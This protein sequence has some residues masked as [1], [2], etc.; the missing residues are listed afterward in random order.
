M[1][2]LKALSKEKLV[3]MVTHNPQLAEE[4]S[5]R[6]VKLLDGSV[7]DDSMP[8]KTDAEIAEKSSPSIVLETDCT[9]KSENEAAQNAK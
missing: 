9:L 4:Y 6:I 5:T 1:D 2:L 7:V 8:F 3:I